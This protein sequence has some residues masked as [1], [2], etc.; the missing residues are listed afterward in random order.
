M[1]A[2]LRGLI[3]VARQNLD[4]RTVPNPTSFIDSFLELEPPKTWSLIATVFGDLEG[5]V[6]SGKEL[7]A[8]LGNVGVKPEAIRV[9]L[10]R[11]KQDDWIV[12]HKSG[13]EVIYSLTKAARAETVAAHSDVY[14]TDVKFADSWHVIVLAQDAASETCAGPCIPFGKGLMLCPN[15]A[16][17]ADMD[18][19]ALEVGPDPVPDWGAARLMPGHLEQLAQRLVV[20]AER[21]ALE[22]A[23]MQPGDIVSARLLFLHHWRK[24]AL[25]TA[26]WAHIGLLPQGVL[27]QCHQ[28]VTAILAS[29]DPTKAPD[30]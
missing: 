25:R 9:A 23:Q 4:G 7:G 18:G 28:S 13:R 30:L 26:T 10:H 12:G 17:P 15:G 27:A 5:E 16:K 2:L 8:L 22:R 20:Q 3:M 11:L 6:L 19:W 1:V 14:R 24:L 29:T 21:F